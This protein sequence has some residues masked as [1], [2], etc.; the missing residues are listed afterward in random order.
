MDLGLSVKDFGVGGGVYACVGT[1]LPVHFTYRPDICLGD[2]VGNP[3]HWEG[4][5]G[6]V[7]PPGGIADCGEA[8]TVMR[9]WELLLPPAGLL[10]EGGGP[11]GDGDLYI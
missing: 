6:G 2:M 5:G 7:P 10:H 8:T 11:G 3:P 9:Q 4:R 1:F